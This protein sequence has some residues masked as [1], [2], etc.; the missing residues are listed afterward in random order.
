MATTYLTDTQGTPTNNIKWTWSSW[1]KRGAL[2]GTVENIFTTYVDASNLFY[3]RF[4]AN[5][6]IYIRNIASVGTGGKLTTNAKYRD[7]AAWYH[8][9]FVYDSANASAGDR[10]RLYVNGVEET[11][12]SLDTNPSSSQVCTMNAD[13]RVVELGRR[14]DEATNFTGI[15]AHTHFCDGQAYAASDFGETDATSG[16]WIPITGPSVTY[17][18]NGFFLKYAAGALGTD[19]SGESND[20]VV[21]GTMTTTKDTPENNFVNINPLRPNS[22]S[23]TYANGNT[24]FTRTGSAGQGNGTM[25]I[26]KGK[27]YYECLIDDVRQYIGWTAG[28]D[29]G[30]TTSCDTAGCYFYG[31]YTTDVG[32]LSTYKNGVWA[33]ETGYTLMAAS[34]VISIAF[35]ADN[36]E[37]YYGT[38]GTWGNSSDPA[39]RT[40]P[41]LTSVPVTSIM[42]PGIGYGDSGAST[43]K[44]NFGNGYF[45]TTSSGTTEA[46][47]AGEG[48][49]KYDVPAGFYALCTNNIATY[50]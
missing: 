14:S 9:V 24:T 13:T 31:F 23:Q 45:G 12:F 30:Q 46:D 38:N 39:A 37:M 32:N 3:I 28:N 48:Q 47:D 26:T 43:I 18:N 41:A 35:D 40:N 42:V 10:M 17:G 25:G 5:D 50:G 44:F 2:S 19:S 16:I 36:G 7:P 27:W 34:Q 1:I 8:I 11:S 29:A 49:F 21:S 6:S 33:S 22:L 15:L 4:E 20:F